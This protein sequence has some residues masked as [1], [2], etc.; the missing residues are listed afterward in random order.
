MPLCTGMRRG[1]CACVRVC[2]PPC[3]PT[4]AVE[5]ALTR[6]CPLSL[7]CGLG[8][9]HFSACVARLGAV[10]CFGFFLLPL[11]TCL[12]SVPAALDAGCVAAAAL[13]PLPPASPVS[14]PHP[15]PPHRHSCLAPVARSWPAAPMPV[16][17]AQSAAT[18][19]KS[20]RLGEVGERVAARCLKESRWRLGEEEERG[21]RGER[22][23]AVG[24]RVVLRHSSFLSLCATHAPKAPWRGHPAPPS[25]FFSHSFTPPARRTTAV[26]LR[27]SRTGTQH[28]P[29][30]SYR[31][32]P[33]LCVSVCV[34]VC[35]PVHGSPCWTTCLVFFLF[36]L[37]H[38]LAAPN[39]LLLVCYL[40][41]PSSMPATLFPHA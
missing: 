6:S 19:T 9:F 23:A 38:P 37:T 35:S 41:L 27:C 18:W 8:L 33:H 10:S 13:P 24:C 26:Q 31:A 7:A 32:C 40:R 21:G 1:A 5:A 20:G 29:F 16:G 39:A 36:L 17:N 4:W 22:R 28:A 30:F 12:T 34:R 25:L 11:C 15:P 14:S 2:R 3:L